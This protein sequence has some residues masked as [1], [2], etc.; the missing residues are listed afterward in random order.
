MPQQGEQGAR[1]LLVD[2]ANSQDG[3]VRLVV[4]EVLATR[5]A[6]S[7]AAISAVKEAFYAEKGL[8]GTKAT[9]TPAL[10]TGGFASDT[11]SQLALESLSRCTNVNKLSPEQDIQFGRKLT[12]LFGEN[13]SGKTGY[14][15]VLKRISGVRGAERVLPDVG[16]TIQANPSAVVKYSIDDSSQEIDWNDEV[17]LSPFTRVA[18]FDSPAVSLHLNENL[19]YVFTP[20]DLSLFQLVHEALCQVRDSVDADVESRQ[21]GANRFLNLLHRGTE[22]YKVIE[23]LT[24]ATPIS[25]VRALSTLSSEQREEIRRLNVRA[26]ALNPAT[27]ENSLKKASA[28]LKRLERFNQTASAATGIDLGNLRRLREDLA[29]AEQEAATLVDP[30][31]DTDE[32]ARVALQAFIQAGE[33][34][35]RETRSA[36]YPEPG[37]NCLYCGQDLSE[38]AIELIR[39]YRNYSSARAVTTL[40]SLRNSIGSI[41]SPISKLDT[42]EL[43]ASLP[44]PDEEEWA[45]PTSDLLIK[46]REAQEGDTY[47]NSLVETIVSD[48]AAVVAAIGSEI[49]AR[50]DDVRAAQASVSERAELREETTAKLHD[51]EDRVKLREL[52][53]DLESYVRDAAWCQRTSVLVGK[54]QALLKS[55]TSVSK[56]ASE[57][58]LQKDFEDRFEEER[59]RLNAPQV[60]LDFP[61]R[62]G[63][64]IRRKKVAEDYRLDEILSEGEQKVIALAD[65]LA[66]S[67]LR[68]GSAPIVFDD[69]VNS[70]D[71]KR[72]QEVVTRIVQLSEDQQ[73]IVFTHNIWFTTELIIRFEK[74]AEDYRYYGI[75]SLGGVK[76]V[77]TP[78]SGPRG[79]TLAQTAKQIDDTLSEADNCQGELRAV[80]I[81]HAYEC[82]RNWCEVFVEGELL[83]KVA[84]RY[85]AH[86][87]VTKLR[88]I[89]FDRLDGASQRVI[90]V[91]EKCCRQIESHSQPRETL[92]VRADLD[93]VRSD[94][95]KA[96]DAQRFYR[97]TL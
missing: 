17:G 18:V 78:G 43:R 89:S 20:A 56:Q 48:S 2:W 19:D 8:T 12:V 75:E 9:P 3:W 38:A 46:I 33:R 90:P 58:A 27:S 92:N 66:E 50:S 54:F 62:R 5:S 15:R 61:G 85:S 26:E 24:G 21:P 74:N 11:P 67:L 34:L 93:E 65:F 25:A 55:I 71:Y 47:S 79:D 23:T 7:D 69:P 77:V 28:S 91:Y 32:E 36:E 86:I 37:D 49:E 10:G 84:E 53:P 97:G 72:L 64:T 59:L 83:Q 13:A 1:E 35:A 4:S 45:R 29:S 81:Q 30:T 70:L 95:T 42:E 76:G 22:P 60:K 41:L 57:R 52:L 63:Q 94:W 6:P 40:P 88:K 80:L 31:R 73:V 51:L 68:V 16:K 44:E 14:V 87:G 96:L 82:M 39:T